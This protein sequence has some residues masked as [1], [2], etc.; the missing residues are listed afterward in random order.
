VEP[1]TAWAIDGGTFLAAVTGHDESAARAAALVAERLD[2]AP[3][4]GSPGAVA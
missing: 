2:G 1:V 3:P 4:T